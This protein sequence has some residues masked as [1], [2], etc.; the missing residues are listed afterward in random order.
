MSAEMDALDDLMEAIA[1]ASDGTERISTETALRAVRLLRDGTSGG[2]T[3]DALRAIAARGASAAP[4]EV[5]W[6]VRHDG[7]EVV[8][9]FP[10]RDYAEEYAD[11]IDGRLVQ[12][13]VSAWREV[14]P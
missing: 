13:T 9:T 2:E 4:T 8:A 11:G 10:E 3:F 1:E 14:Q 7:G 12:R 6:G 5:E